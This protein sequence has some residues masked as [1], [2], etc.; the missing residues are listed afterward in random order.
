MFDV[1]G[2]WLEGTAI[3]QAIKMHGWMFPTI[4]SIHVLMF[5]IV[6]GMIAIMDLRLLGI[7]SNARSVKELA[8]ETLGWVWLA[9]IVAVTTGLLMFV[10][11]AQAYLANT[12]F[13]VKMG[14]IV[15]AGM[16]MMYFELIS[17]RTV[18]AWH[19]GVPT[20]KAAK[21]AAISSLTLW[22]GV[23]VCGRLIGFTLNMLSGAPDMS[24]YL[25]GVT[26]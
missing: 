22:V 12:F 8:R 3:S 21:F 5:T 15:V 23:V 9:F 19:I 6:V 13:L 20:S 18:D 1:I 17:V 10:S 26:Q 24:Q 14:L 7:P 11:Q 4:E 25:T 2:P 16:N